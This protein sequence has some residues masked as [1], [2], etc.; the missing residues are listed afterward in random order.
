MVTKETI[1][2]V[3]ADGIGVTSIE[4]YADTLREAVYVAAN[5]YAVE[6]LRNGF[7]FDG[8]R[9]TFDDNGR[10]L[11]RFVNFESDGG[12]SEELTFE[13][14]PKPKPDTFGNRFET[15]KE[16]A[17]YYRGLVAKL[18]NV[19]YDSGVEGD[20][21]SYRDEINAVIETASETKYENGV[22]RT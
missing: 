2:V 10:G 12:F 13:A 4:V 21:D 19:F 20:Y 18:E 3:L 5:G 15:A 14:I 17:D 9:L 7:S 16:Y 1:E 6:S 11:F 8:Y 22:Y